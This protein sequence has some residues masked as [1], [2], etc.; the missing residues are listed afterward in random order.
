MVTFYSEVEYV[1]LVYIRATRAEPHPTQREQIAVYSVHPS[2]CEGLHGI[3]VALQR[4]VATRPTYGLPSAG[5]ALL[6]YPNLLSHR[7]S[8]GKPAFGH[9]CLV[10]SAAPPYLYS[11]ERFWNRCGE[12][13]GYRPRK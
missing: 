11:G 5:M 6:I 7:K 1:N 12:S 3:S 8:K 2:Y 9:D 13:A 10:N 4:L